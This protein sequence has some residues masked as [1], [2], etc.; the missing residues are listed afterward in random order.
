MRQSRS[1]ENIALE[2]NKQIVGTSAEGRSED[3]DET[4]SLAT[5]SGEMAQRVGSCD[6]AATCAGP[7]EQWLL[8]P[9]KKRGK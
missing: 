6:R 4:H 2:L 5:C 9:I 7:T 8:A 1:G 3:P